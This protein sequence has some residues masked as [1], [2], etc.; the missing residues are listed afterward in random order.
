[1]RLKVI[2]KKLDVLARLNR[3]SRG[4]AE[5]I[6]EEYFGLLVV[7]IGCRRWGRGEDG[8]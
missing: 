6:S 2:C 3:F 4:K 5:V 8:G 7:I 1:M